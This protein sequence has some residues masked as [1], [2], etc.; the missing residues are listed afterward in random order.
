MAIRGKVDLVPKR[1]F[2][3]K[4]FT[5]T[6][7]YLQGRSA[8]WFGATVETWQSNIVLAKK[9][10]HNYKCIDKK[11]PNL[12]VKITCNFHILTVLIINFLHTWSFCGKSMFFF[13]LEITKSTF[14]IHK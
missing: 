3:A 13:K 9:V 2:D 14:C 7:A 8:V 10:A 6:A 5:Q 11:K 1:S 4:T 12:K